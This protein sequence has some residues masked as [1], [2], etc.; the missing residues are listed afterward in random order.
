VSIFRSRTDCL[1]P[2]RSEL[3]MNRRFLASCAE[4]LVAV[5]HKRGAHAIGG[6][7]C[8]IPLEHDTPASQFALIRVREDKLREAWAGYDGT[9]V[10]HPWLIPHA[11]DVF[12][13]YV[14]FPHQLERKKQAC[15]TAADLLCLPAGEV[16]DEGLSAAVDIGL[17]YLRGG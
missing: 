7:S 5:C 16:G 14:P 15:A 10:A 13:T 9:Q 8:E 4:Q 3:N 2:D 6:V 17:R 12:D 1:L 11:R